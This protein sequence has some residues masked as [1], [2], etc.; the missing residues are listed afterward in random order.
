MCGRYDLNETGTRLKR[1]FSLKQVP[2]FDPHPDLRPTDAA[3]VVRLDRKG[4]REAVLMHGLRTS[5]RKDGKD[6]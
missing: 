2:L 6:A 5:I 1:V 4:A 3:L